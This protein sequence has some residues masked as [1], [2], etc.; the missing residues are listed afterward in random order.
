VINE[1]DYVA[2]R[3]RVAGEYMADE[4]LKSNL[5]DLPDSPDTDDEVEDDLAKIGLKRL[6]EAVVA[7]TDWTEFQRNFEPGVPPASFF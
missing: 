7:A 5:S 6:S 1:S 4:E 3:K 2:K